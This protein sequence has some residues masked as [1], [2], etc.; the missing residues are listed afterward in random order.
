V[1]SVASIALVCL[2]S[3]ILASACGPG[4]TRSTAAPSA[5]SAGERVVTAG[6][7]ASCASG[8]DEA[9]AKLVAGIE[10]TVAPLGDEAYENGSAMDFRDCYEPTWSRFKDRTRPVPGNH[11]YETPGARGYFDYFGEVYYSYDL[12]AWWR[13]TATCASR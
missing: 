11:E 9:T 10:G 4:A 2:A 12:G 1:R 3:A 13:S 8:G 7:I 6:D 5:Q